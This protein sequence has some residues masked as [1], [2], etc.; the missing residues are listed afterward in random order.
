MS[1]YKPFLLPVALTVLITFIPARADGL[2]VPVKPEIRI[3]GGWVVDYHRVNI[4][5]RNQVAS[6]SI[7]QKFRNTGSGMIEVEYLF[8]V[9]PD[10]AIDSMT[11]IV[12]GKE[13]AAK[14][15]GANEARKIY[16]DIV[17]KKKDPALLEYAGYGLYRTRSFPLEPDK[18]VRVQVS[19]KSVCKRDGS[20]VEV[21]YPLNTEKFSAKKIADVS[22]VT[23]I[24]TGTDITTVYSPSHEIDCRRTATDHVIVEYKAQNVLPTID[25]Q[26]FYGIDEKDVGASFLTYRPKG[27]N[28]GYFLML[29]SPNPNIGKK[30]LVIP[31][32]LVVVVDRS[33]SMSGKKIRQAVEA[34]RF[35]LE[36]LNEDDRFNVITYSDGV[37]KVFPGPVKASRQNIETAIGEIDAIGATGG[38][39]TDTA[40]K[41]A[42]GQWTKKDDSGRPRYVMFL[43][44]GKPTVGVT[45]VKEILKN[46]RKANRCGARVFAF[47]VG[48]NVNIR[49]LDKLVIDHRGLSDYVKPAESVESKISSL[50]SKIRNPVMTNIEVLIEHVKLTDIYPREIGDLFDG[51]Q[52]VVSG[53]YQGNDVDRLPTRESGI[54][55][56]RLTISGDYTGKKKVFEYDVE[57]R[58]G[59]A[60]PS[61]AF[62][63]K[64]WATRR[65]G[66]LL[67]QIQLNGESDEITDELIRLSKRYGIMTPYTSFLADETTVL[68]RPEEVRK[69]ADK[70]ASKL[71][72]AHIGAEGQMGAMARQQL[73]RAEKTSA[74]STPGTPGGARL[75]GNTSLSSYEKNKTERLGAVRNIGNQTLYRRGQVWV[76]ANASDVDLEKAEKIE[77]VKRYSKKYFELVKANTREENRILSSQGED[78]E[79]VIRLRGQVYRIK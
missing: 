24:K 21:W 68:H 18:P 69:M 36:H 47:G 28:T 75:Y 53:R 73:N 13:Y 6:V 31:K 71:A 23:D 60:R 25:L 77:T 58:P 26:L 3:R 45:D 40:I 49:L 78:E 22:V 67:D 70:K 66:F 4:K 43:T 27:E 72:E 44:D 42:M 61:R 34:T 30:V 32:D 39:A 35:V 37:E 9:P 2:I 54:N 79:L 11:L 1:K 17:R 65:V 62:V 19:Y 57:F 12:G 16:E 8:P 15:L 50:Y 52:L 76:A 63:E 5:V 64:I 48:Y 55:I 59:A 46:A 33:G 41:E 14:L 10:A 29:V 51:D 38:T 20:T 56:A 7:D 74:D